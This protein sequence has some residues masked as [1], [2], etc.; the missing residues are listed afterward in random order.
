MPSQ[1]LRNIGTR[2]ISYGFPVSGIPSS[3]QFHTSQGDEQ[4]ELCIGMRVT[5]LFFGSGHVMPSI[6]RNMSPKRILVHKSSKTP[7]YEFKKTLIRSLYRILGPFWFGTT[8]LA[9]LDPEKK[10]LNGLFSLLNM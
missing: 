10:S 8:Y 3:H 4:G 1:V 7:K 2:G 6:A 9:V 5:I